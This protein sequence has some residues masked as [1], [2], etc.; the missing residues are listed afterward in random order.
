M[1]EEKT[2]WIKE[3]PETIKEKIIELAK[4]N[5]PTEKIGLTLRDEHGIPKVKIFGLRISQVLKEAGMYKDSEY[6]NALRKEETLKKH[7]LKNKH[8]YKAQRTI[9]QNRGKI[10]KIRKKIK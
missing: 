8:D 2:S 1:A 10:N 7:V 9:V 6:E 5:I 4:Q 3:K